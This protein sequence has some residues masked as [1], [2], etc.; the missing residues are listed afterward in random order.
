MYMLRGSLITHGYDIAVV[1]ILVVKFEVIQ[2][3]RQRESL[4]EVRERA[5]SCLCFNFL[6]STISHIS[7]RILRL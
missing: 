5:L 2:K 1:H 3:E 6:R 7:Q 4:F